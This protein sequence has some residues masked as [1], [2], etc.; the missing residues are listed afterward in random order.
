ML[1]IPYNTRYYLDNTSYILMSKCPDNLLDYTDYNYDKL[2]ALI[3][4]SNNK[5]NVMVFNKNY[6]HPELLEKNINRWY[7]S[8]LNTP[9]YPSNNINKSYMFSGRNKN[10]I[11]YYLP[12]LF[13]PYFEYFKSIDSRYNQVVVNYYE[14]ENDNIDYH[15]DWTYGMVKDYV[16]SILNLNSR[17]NNASR[18]FEINNI[19]NNKLYRIELHDGLVITLGGD[20]QKN[21]RHGIP[22]ISNNSIYNSRFGITFRQ[23]NI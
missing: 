18:V 4:T 9:D 23:F 3:K 8:Y 20:F 7:K 2:K 15:R 13:V 10:E 1:S 11:Q 21:Y 12:I 16:I 14:N 5:S 6:T 17:K 19:I 22:K